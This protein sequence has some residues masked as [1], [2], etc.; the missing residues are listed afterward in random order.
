MAHI[1]FDEAIQTYR[2]SLS[3]M[4]AALGFEKPQSGIKGG[5][6]EFDSEGCRVQEPS[7]RAEKTPAQTRELGAK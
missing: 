7:G 2:V 5:Y 6:Q 4:V 1:F 3:D